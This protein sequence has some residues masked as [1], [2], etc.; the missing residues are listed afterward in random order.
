MHLPLIWPS[1]A[2]DGWLRAVEDK[3]SEITPLSVFS[4][5]IVSEKHAA[6][7][8][9][10]H[11]IGVPTAFSLLPWNSWA[12]NNFDSGHYPP[13]Q[14]MHLKQAGVWV[15]KMDLSPRKFVLFDDLP[16]LIKLLS[17]WLVSGRQLSRM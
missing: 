11:R 10:A 7:K 6:I 12:E 5:A 14:W 2:E 15:A 17:Q 13:S 4:A 16:L 8:E 1:G 3:A 9:L